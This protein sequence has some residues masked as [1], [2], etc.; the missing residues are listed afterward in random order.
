MEPKLML[1]LYPQVKEPTWPPTW[2]DV[3]RLARTSP[4]ARSMIV[5][6]E[7]GSATREQALI[8]VLFH[9]Y[10]AYAMLY[11]LR[12]DDLMN[13]PPKPFIIDGKTYTPIE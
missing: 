3:E 1:D 7:R 10:N 6:V 2:E 8:Q 12:V 5:A 13:Q 11:R 9:L 4:E